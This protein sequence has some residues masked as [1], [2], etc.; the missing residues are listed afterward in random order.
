MDLELQSVG[1]SRGQ[2]LG[3]STYSELLSLSTELTTDMASLSLFTG[4]L[5]V[6]VG[7]PLGRACF[8][9]FATPD[10]C[11]CGR[12]GGGSLIDTV[13][14]EGGSGNGL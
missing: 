2:F 9:F 7:P 11:W 12:V 6:A 10:F 5:V 8:D 3:E 13:G 4:C 14:R 1:Q